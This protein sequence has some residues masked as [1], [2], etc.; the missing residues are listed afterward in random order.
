MG[1]HKWVRREVDRRTLPVFEFQ[2][3]I[4]IDSK[5]LNPKIEN[6]TFPSFKNYG[7]FKTYR[8]VQGKQLSPLVKLPNRNRI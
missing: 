4:Q 7:K 6:G 8:L 5:L 2:R 3:F 1:V